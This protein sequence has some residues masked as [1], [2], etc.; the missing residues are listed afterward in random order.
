MWIF[1]HGPWLLHSGAQE[2]TSPGDRLQLHPKVLM[3]VMGML[4]HCS[5]I[6][7]CAGTRAPTPQAAGSI[8]LCAHPGNR[9][10]MLEV[11]PAPNP[12]PLCRF[13]LLPQHLPKPTREKQQ[14]GLSLTESGPSGLTGNS[15]YG[16][17]P[18]NPL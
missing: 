7:Q 6:P 11:A 8:L 1:L 12:D 4:M 3:G 2:R 10:F 9:D 14:L 18:S 13:G 17:A 15:G 5:C 16:L